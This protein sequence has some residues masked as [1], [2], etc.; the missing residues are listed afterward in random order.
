MLCVL[1]RRNC[2]RKFLV[3]IKYNLHLFK[4]GGDYL[5]IRAALKREGYHISLAQLSLQSF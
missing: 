3:S 2:A 1:V 4:E 5:N